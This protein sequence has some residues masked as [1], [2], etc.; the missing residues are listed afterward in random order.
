MRI[1]LMSVALFLILA[2]GV[3]AQDKAAVKIGMMDSLFE[4]KDEK[5]IFAQMEPFSEHVKKRSGVEGEFV[6]VKGIESMAKELKAGKIHLAVLQGIEYGWVLQECPDCKPLI[7]AVTDSPTLKAHVLVAVDSPIKSLADL[8][9][10]ALAMPR[11]APPYTR[12]YVEREIK[13]D[14]D[15]FFKLSTTDNT[16]AA[17]EAVVEGK[18]QATIVSSGALDVYKQLKPGRF[19]RLKVLE[20]SADFPAA[21]VIYRPGQGREKELAQFKD[22][23]LKAG[24]N[25]EGRQMLTLWRLS[26]FQEVPKDYQKIVEEIVKRYPRN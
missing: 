22:A 3:P 7:I 8:K 17:I 10:Q 12:L 20:E 19:K 11:R 21:V 14:P 1:A 2:S 13:D 23:L 9:G 16:D 25:A 24:D 26:G 18:A 5:T 4:E 15:R 6:V